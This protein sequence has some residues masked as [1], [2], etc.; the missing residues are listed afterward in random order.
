M[1]RIAIIIMILLF[2][3]ESRADALQAFDAAVRAACPQ[4]DGVSLGPPR[5]VW[6]SKGSACQAAGDAVVS[7]FDPNTANTN[8]TKLSR[9]AFLSRL[10]DMELAAVLQAVSANSNAQIWW[11]RFNSKDSIDLTD[12]FLKRGLDLLVTNGAITAQREAE[13]LTP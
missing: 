12:P 13:L 11:A 10:T 4:I 9:A 2:S 7:S 8:S 3:A 1:A 6:Y 5:V